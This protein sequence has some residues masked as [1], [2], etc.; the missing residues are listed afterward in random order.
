MVFAPEPAWTRGK[1][2]PAAGSTG[3][4]TPWH[5]FSQPG[6]F[7]AKFLTNIKPKNHL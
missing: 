6:I 1:L 2:K 7:T 4:N 3:V 5:A